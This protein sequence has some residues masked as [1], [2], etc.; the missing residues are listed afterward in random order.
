MA[1]EHTELDDADFVRA[2]QIRMLRQALRHRETIDLRTAVVS[3]ENGLLRRDLT[4]LLSLDLLKPIE[5]PAHPRRTDVQLGPSLFMQDNE[6]HP[7][8]VNAVELLIN[9]AKEFRLAGIAHF[10]RLHEAERR[11]VAPKSAQL[12]RALSEDIASDDADR[13]R[14]AGLRVFDRLQ[15]DFL[16]HLAGL[17]QAVEIGADELYSH[18]LPKVMRPTLAALD[19]VTPPVWSTAEQGDEISRTLHEQLGSAKTVE[20]AASKYYLLCGHLPL[21]GELAFD[22]FIERWEKQNGPNKRIWERLWCWADKQRSPLP[23]YHVSQLFISRASHRSESKRQQLW[24]EVG[25]IVGVSLPEEKRHHSSWELRCDLARHYA[26]HLLSLSPGLE[27]DRIAAFALWAAE[28]VASLFPEDSFDISS[29]RRDLASLMSESEEAFF[30]ARTRVPPSE[31][32]YATLWT[33]SIWELSVLCQLGPN[34]RKLRPDMMSDQ[35]REAISTALGGYIVGGLPVFKQDEDVPPESTEYSFSTSELNTVVVWLPYVDNEQTAHTLASL[36]KAKVTWSQDDDLRSA[37]ERLAEGNE[38]EQSIVCHILRG[39][40]AYE[41]VDS[42]VILEHLGCDEWR[43]AVFQRCP[44]APLEATLEALEDLAIRQEGELQECL[45]HYVALECG[46]VTD[47][48]R[49]QLL[50]A[51]TLIMSI[52][53]ETL[54][55]LRRLVKPPLREEY[56][57][58]VLFWRLR[59]KG[60][61]R[62]TSPWVSARIRAAMSV[63]PDIGEASSAVPGRAKKGKKG[64]KK[65]ARGK[66]VEK[67]TSSSGRKKAKRH[68]PRKHK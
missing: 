16:V 63:L 64:V 10:E 50:F 31:L 55:G 2:C 35:Q 60:M 4:N 17:A 18:Y 65:R 47:R 1:S 21:A 54:S 66:E 59:L 19:S 8:I 61:Q 57:E 7:T 33:R 20:E 49:Q 62:V 58:D 48:E 51:Y 11:R 23:R 5:Q 22:S 41:R 27:G 6:D 15:D 30:V 9:P 68:P 25:N 12:L 32:L 53:F 37:L 36:A 67:E 26:R 56:S 44:L 14:P 39:R 38:W 46:L 13:W 3:Q 28:Q 45:P 40:A 52:N 29:L 24:Q 43:T 34:L 42:Q